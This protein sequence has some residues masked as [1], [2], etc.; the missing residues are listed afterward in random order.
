LARWERTSAALSHWLLY[1]IMI[2]M[3]ISGYLFSAW[4]GHA[5]TYFGLFT[6]PGLE[7]ND[8]L[9]KVAFWAPVAI[10]QW[11]TYAL[12][13]LHIVATGWHVARRRDGMLFRMLPKQSAAT[14]IAESDK[15]Y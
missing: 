9:Q 14:G 3:P 8:L 10:G 4:G 5:V 1:L 11:L 2:G 13:A 15:P 7:K 12:I 6:F